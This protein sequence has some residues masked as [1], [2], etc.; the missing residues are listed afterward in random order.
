MYIYL[1]INIFTLLGPLALSF[2]KKVAF[3]RKWRYVFPAI[4]A[5]GLFFI[6]WDVW[7]T[8]MGVW[9][10]N[11]EYLVGIYAWGLPLEEWLF[12]LTIPYACVFIYECLQAYF[13]KD[14]LKEIAQPLA[15]GM[16]GILLGLALW[17]VGQWYTQVTFLLAACLL[18]LNA[19]VTRPHYLGRF[20]LAYVI[21]L[22]PF[23]IVN[24]IL[25]SMPVVM[26]NDAENFGLRL[27]TIPV[28]D[29]IYSLLLFLMN[30]NL[31]EY[32]KARATRTGSLQSQESYV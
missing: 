19:L 17:G 27:G 31:Y 5:V 18:V 20:F 21:H 23:L 11:P 4:I 8:E 6:A 13:P 29:T 7:F 1:L 24:G 32:L 3:F 2:D 22:I 9:S 14:I 10:F 26:Y 15:L 16:S 25:T 30:I 12:F 28:E